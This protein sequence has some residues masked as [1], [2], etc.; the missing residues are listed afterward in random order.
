MFLWVKLGNF[1]VV[2][3]TKNLEVQVWKIKIESELKFDRKFMRHILIFS[4]KRMAF[5]RS[6]NTARFDRLVSNSHAIFNLRAQNSLKNTLIDFF[7]QSDHQIWIPRH[8]RFN[9]LKGIIISAPSSSS[10]SVTDIPIQH[11]FSAIVSVI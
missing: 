6:E 4:F 5:F 1:L 9:G 10:H 3:V 8:R 7:R 11:I 2:Y